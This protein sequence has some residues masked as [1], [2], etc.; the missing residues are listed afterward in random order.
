MEAQDGGPS[1]GKR[2]VGHSRPSNSLMG[3]SVTN[4]MKLDRKENSTIQLCL[5]DLVLLNFLREARTKELW[6]K[7]GTL[8]QYKSFGK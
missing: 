4:W 6:D 8:Y 7:L 5:L 1:C 3:M 2:I